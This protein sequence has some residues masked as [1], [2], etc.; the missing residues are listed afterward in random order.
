LKSDDVG[1]YR[2]F[3]ICQIESFIGIVQDIYG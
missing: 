2:Y 3:Q 1:Y